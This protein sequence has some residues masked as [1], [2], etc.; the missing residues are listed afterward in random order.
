M[1]GLRSRGPGSASA[2]GRRGPTVLSRHRP[3]SGFAA[4]GVLGPDDAVGQDLLGRADHDRIG[5]RVVVAHP[6]DFE[7]VEALWI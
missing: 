3:A 6:V 1:C 2:P 7:A 4:A 5:P